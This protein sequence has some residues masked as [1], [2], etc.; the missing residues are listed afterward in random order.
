[1]AV[2]AELH[3]LGETLLPRPL[4]GYC[5]THLHTQT[6]QLHLSQQVATA[7]PSCRAQEM[8]HNLCSR[9]AAIR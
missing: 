2:H 1:M 3:V 7:L 6:P 4:S 8:W 5:S 9:G